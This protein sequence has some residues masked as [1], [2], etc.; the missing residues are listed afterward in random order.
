MALRLLR[1]LRLDILWLD[2]DDLI[3]C[4]FWS[5]VFDSCQPHVGN[6][7]LVAYNDKTLGGSTMTL[8]LMIREP[9]SIR[10]HHHNDSATVRLHRPRY[11]RTSFGALTRD[12][13]DYD[14]KARFESLPDS[15]N[16]LDTRGLLTRV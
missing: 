13:Q 11:A 3:L 5:A 1:R 14:F 6:T 8:P 2:A 9:A 10:Q 4:R 15:T 7:D 12:M 16:R